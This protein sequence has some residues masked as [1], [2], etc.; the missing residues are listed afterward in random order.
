[1]PPACLA[2]RGGAD[3]SAEPRDPFQADW[4]PYG[5]QYAPEFI[6]AEHQRKIDAE[7]EAARRANEA[8]ME[9]RKSAGLV[10][11]K[12]AA[13]DTGFTLVLDAVARTADGVTAR[14]CGRSVRVGDPIRGL[15]A[16]PEPV[17]LRVDGTAADVAWRGMVVTVRLDGPPVAVSPPPVPPPP[18]AQTAPVVTDSEPPSPAENPAV[19]GVRR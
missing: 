12:R 18:P 5:P 15:S 2:R 6:A 4:A 11:A 19:V 13:A 1:V 9:R 10:Q 17:L 14:I 8:A 16:A 7:R 3:K